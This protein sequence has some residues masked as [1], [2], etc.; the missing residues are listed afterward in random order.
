MIL[1]FKTP[2]FCC[3]FSSYQHTVYSIDAQVGTGRP[4]V[5]IVTDVRHSGLGQL[6]LSH[7]LVLH[8]YLEMASCPLCLAANP[9]VIIDHMGKTNSS[10]FIYFNCVSFFL[11]HVLYTNISVEQTLFTFQPRVLSTSA[12][13]GP[14][15]LC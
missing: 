8:R 14:G 7:I 3:D 11:S 12:Y 6:Y 13:K 4:L 15:E 2:F 9:G 1:L 5:V 10:C